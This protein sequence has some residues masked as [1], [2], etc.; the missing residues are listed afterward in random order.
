MM[1]IPIFSMGYH[2]FL[3]RVCLIAAFII[4]CVDSFAQQYF[5]VLSPQGIIVQ[6]AGFATI[7][8]TYER[9]SA[10]DRKIFGDLVPFDELWRTGAGN[11]TKIKFDK[12][13]VI[14]GRRLEPGTYS[15][16]TIPAVQ[17][18]T[19]ILNSDTTLYG[20]GGYDQSRDMVRFKG[21]AEQ[22][23]RYY[24]SFTIDVDVVSDNALITISWERTSTSFTVDT[25]TDEALVKLTNDLL[26]SK[27]SLDSQRLA[28]GAE[29]YYFANRD[30]EMGLALVN[31]A[32]DIQVNAWY[33]SLKTD[34][35]VKSERYAEA[36]ETLRQSMS[37]VKSNPENWSKEQLDNVL[38]G[39]LIQMK[40][41]QSQIK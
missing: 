32:L 16:F 35:L 20:T 39:Q 31:R 33:Y 38:A 17:D 28:M 15:L 36:I 12:S 3:T 5:P 2:S 30:L 14:A 23:S 19:I 8:I 37:Y 9:P 13:V 40:E 22:A 21:K 1:N 6:K 10:R 26:L 25:E 18:W 34:I 24:E 27:E 29:Y 11:C 7:T 4:G 41:L